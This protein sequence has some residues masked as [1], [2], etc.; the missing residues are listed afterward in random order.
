MRRLL[1]YSTRIYTYNLNENDVE[2]IRNDLK[3]YN[4]MLHIAYRKC[5]DKCFYHVENK[6][7]EKQLKQEFKTSD[8]LPLSAINEAKGL[9]K[10]NIEKNKT[11]QKQVKQ[12]I[13]NIENK[14]KEVNKKLKYYEKEQEKLIQ[15]CKV[16]DYTEKDYLY[17]VK[18]V[19]P[20][21]KQ[22]KNRLKMLHFRKKE[23]S[24]N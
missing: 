22:L 24:S 2:W 17:E 4:K 7:L 9:L 14:I 8:Y 10:A 23:M 16:Y 18:T 20:Q 15:K 1:A 3:L 13:D 12:R 21:I 6:E 19:K 11:D 5:Y